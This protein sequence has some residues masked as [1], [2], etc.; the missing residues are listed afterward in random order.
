MPVLVAVGLAFTTAAA[1]T[2]AVRMVVVMRMSVTAAAAA[3]F[4]AVA[5]TT[6]AATTAGAVNVAV[7]KLLLSRVALGYQ[8]YRED[9][10]LARERMIRVQSHL[11]AIDLHHA[12]DRR[13]TVLTGLKIVADLYLVHRKLRNVDRIDLGFI[14][15]TITLFRA[16]DHVLA[17]ACV[18]LNQALFETFDDLANAREELERTP[19]R[20]LIQDLA[21]LVTQGVVEADDLLCRHF[22]TQSA[23]LLH[24]KP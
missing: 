23:R 17:L 22:P 13:M 19:F 10:I 16:D 11:I 4:F 8:L 7:G 5:M 1:F 14:A 15:K 2:F 21:G 9:E 24:G 3:T 6:T 18:H 20:G 12:N